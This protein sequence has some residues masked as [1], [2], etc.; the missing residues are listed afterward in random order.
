MIAVNHKSCTIECV[1]KEMAMDSKQKKN[2]T[3]A[4]LDVISTSMEMITKYPDQS[5]LIIYHMKKR[6]DELLFEYMEVES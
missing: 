1:I 6:L 3:I 2:Y 5:A 4:S